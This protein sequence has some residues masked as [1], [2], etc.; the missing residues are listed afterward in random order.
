VNLRHV[1]A[2]ASIGWYLMI[3]PLDNNKPQANLPVSEYWQHQS[4]DSARECEASKEGYLKKY[5]A[6]AKETGMTAYW[7]GMMESV[8]QGL[9]IATD[10]PRLKGN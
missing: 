3:P 6:N 8:A 2:L 9:C 1:A 5:Q 10:D 4:F 7:T